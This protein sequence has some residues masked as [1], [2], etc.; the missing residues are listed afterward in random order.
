MKGESEED[1]CE[2][3]IRGVPE[4]GD[5][6]AKEISPPWQQTRCGCLLMATT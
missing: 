4:A 5:S 1:I 3:D 6:A 2:V